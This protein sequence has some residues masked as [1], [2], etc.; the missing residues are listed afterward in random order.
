VCVVCYL[1]HISVLV[2]GYFM[3]VEISEVS[4]GSINGDVVI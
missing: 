1:L 4:E 2:V 3:L